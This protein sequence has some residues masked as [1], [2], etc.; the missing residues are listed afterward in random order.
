MSKK[1]PRSRHRIPSFVLEQKS[2]P[3]DDR[4][5]VEVEASTA[6]LER[7]YRKLQKALANAEAKA[8]RI[9]EET[10]RLAAAK[11]DAERIA[12]HRAEEESKL[13]QRINEIREAAKRARVDQQRREIERQRGEVARKRAAL[14]ELRKREAQQARER[15]IQIRRK[16]AESLTLAQTIE[17]RRR[18]LR[19]IE[20]LMM[21]DVYNNRDSRKRGARHETGAA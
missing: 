4:Y 5:E 6:R 21:P 3:I 9:A 17:E 18:E 2:D 12:A 15:E 10:A 7:R 11:A 20:R 1:P 14:I 8:S 19:E 13:A 16:A